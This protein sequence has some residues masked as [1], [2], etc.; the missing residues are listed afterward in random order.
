LECIRRIRAD[1]NH[2]IPDGIQIALDQSE[3]AQLDVTVRTPTLTEEHDDQGP[4][5]QLL[6]ERCGGSIHGEDRHIDR[7]PGTDQQRSYVLRT[8]RVV[9]SKRSA[10]Q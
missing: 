7:H 10:A 3:L 8:G 4:L 5:A 2:T 1:R 6:L 9:E